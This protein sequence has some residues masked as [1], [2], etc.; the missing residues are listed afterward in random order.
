MFFVYMNYLQTTT[1]RLVVIFLLCS[2]VGFSQSITRKEVE[3]KIASLIRSSHS[4]V[5]VAVLD[6]DS[7]EKMGFND[8]KHYPMQSVFK[9]HLGLAVLKKIDE[10]VLSL[11]QIVDVKKEKLDTNTWSPMIK[12]YPNQDLHVSIKDLLRYTVEQSDNNACDILFE[13]VGGPAKVN[14]YIHSTGVQDI[15]I[16]ATEGEMKKA[17]SVQFTNWSTPTAAVQLLE[18]FYKGNLLKKAQHDF[19]WELLVHSI[20]SERLQTALPKDAVVGHKSGTSGRN[21]QGV[22]AAFNDIGIVNLSNGKHFAIALFVSDS[23]ESDEATIQL[24][25][26]ITKVVWEYYK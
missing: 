22:R 6:L 24:M 13:L 4:D 2:T 12:E 10:G 3:G 15:K 26:D 25:K 19:L 8:K 21:A 20:R 23:K 9:F 7:G 16:S 14:A 1:F 5:G 18:K 17:W 11:D